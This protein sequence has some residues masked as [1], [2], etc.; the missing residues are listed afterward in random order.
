MS[1][2]LR[3]SASISCPPVQPSPPASRCRPLHTSL[4][5]QRAASTRSPDL[6]RGCRPLQIHSITEILIFFN[7]CPFSP[8]TSFLGGLSVHVASDCFHR[9]APRAVFSPALCGPS[10]GQPDTPNPEHSL[11]A[12]LFFP[13]PSLRSP[14][15]GSQE[16]ISVTLPLLRAL[17]TFPADACTFRPLFIFL[18]SKIY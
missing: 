12:C 1:R 3:A 16:L 6:S 4:H 5:T 18:P 9:L 13:L 17:L 8:K 10:L 11:L 14:P 15:F 7:K 2:L